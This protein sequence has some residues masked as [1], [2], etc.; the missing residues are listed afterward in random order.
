MINYY[1]KSRSFSARI[2]SSFHSSSQPFAAQN[3]QPSLSSLKVLT[4]EKIGG[5]R[6]ISFDRSPFK[7]FSRKFSKE[8]VQAPSCERLKTTQ[9][10]LFLLFAN[11]N[12]F[13]ITLLC[14]AAT[15]F[16]HR[17]LNW[18]IGIVHLPRYLRWR[19]KSG[20]HNK[21]FQTTLSIH[22]KFGVS[23]KVLHRY[24]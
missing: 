15:H 9:R 4:N 11:N 24:L 1:S 18:N 8:S 7:L 5:L 21:S 16:S 13:P 22:A 10:P 17:K 6:V 3:I 12:W 19:E 14:L 20:L 23:A 2:Q